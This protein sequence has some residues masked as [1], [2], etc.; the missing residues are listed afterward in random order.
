M[1]MLA[2]EEGNYLLSTLPIDEFNR[3]KPHLQLVSMSY[4]EILYREREKL[5]YIYFPT[6]ASFSLL[7]SLEDGSMIEVA[8]V[9]NEGAL[10]ISVCLGNKGAL[11]NAAVQTSGYSFR[12]S[13]KLLQQEFSKNTA[14]WQHLMRYIHT[15]FLQISQTT[16][17]NRRHTVEQQLSRWLLLNFDRLRSCSLISTHEAISNLLGVRRESITDAAVKLQ[18][19]GMINYSRGHIKIINRA[20]LENRACECYTVMRKELERFSCDLKIATVL[21]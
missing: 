17:C 6:T 3:L 9:G 13:A 20:A 5:Q 14:L 12:L 10:G 7:C 8:G 15:L 11:L 21:G 1:T 18:S 4:G 19:A 2:K 16:A